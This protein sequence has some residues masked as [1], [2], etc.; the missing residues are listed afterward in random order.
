[1]FDKNRLWLFRLDQLNQTLK[2]KMINSNMNFGATEDNQSIS[3][4]LNG[5]DRLTDGFLTF[6]TRVPM[7][8]MKTLRRL[9]SVCSSLAC[10]MKHNNSADLRSVT[11]ADKDLMNVKKKKST[12]HSLLQTL[13]VLFGL[14]SLL[15]QE[16]ESHRV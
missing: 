4:C 7:S 14:F 9:F 10:L 5:S 1:M 11:T 3:F 8:W 12:Y 16:P 2:S 6:L 15:I 13:Q